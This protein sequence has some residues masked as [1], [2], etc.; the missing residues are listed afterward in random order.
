[1]G[2][3][4]KKQLNNSGINLTQY[5]NFP[6]RDDAILDLF[7]CNV[8][9]AYKCSISAPLG[10]SDHNV[11]HLMPIYRSSFL[12]SKIIRTSQNI[13]KENL[14]VLD[15]IFDST[16][17]SIFIESCQNIDE[18]A[19]TVCCYI[20]FCT[21]NDTQIKTCK[22]YG[23]NKP[24]YNAELRVKMHE[25]SKAFKSPEFSEK[26][27]EY[28][29]AISKAKNVYKKNIETMF[30]NNK[31]GL[32]W[33]SVKILG[34]IDKKDKSTG[35]IS[36][37]DLDKLNTFFCRHEKGPL[38][39]PVMFESGDLQGSPFTINEVSK[40]L[41]NVNS[42]KA[43]GPDGVKNQVLK[44]CHGALASIFC[45]IFNLSLESGIVPQIWKLSE[46]VPISKNPAPKE[47]NDYR[48]VALTSV[49]VKCLE[50][51]IKKMK[52]YTDGRMD[53]W[54]FAYKPNV[55][56]NDALCCLHELASHHLNVC[57]KHTVRML[58][59]DYSSAFITKTLLFYQR[60]F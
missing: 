4:N 22:V 48:P 34:G 12:Q 7:Y 8:E 51:L 55:S 21:E 44:F 9:S 30:K 33:R 35:C 5:V 53:E 50:K 15:S 1:M 57:S 25:M 26:R 20:N 6:T 58:C 37:E 19:D 38:I 16:D 41:G 46:V 56:T 40:C 52:A 11:L 17:W 13:T 42:K 27:I 2:D 29:K 45:Y 49:V 31:T 10:K 47:D 60:L 39:D 24:W 18:L 3:F 54:Q 32:A 36:K 43:S 28:R 59:L 14:E 23:N